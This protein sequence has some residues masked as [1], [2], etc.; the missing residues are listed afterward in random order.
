M[1][2]VH[3]EL[4]A[5]GYTR[6]VG[7]LESLRSATWMRQNLR[8]DNPPI[9]LD[10]GDWVLAEKAAPY[11]DM[12][13]MIVYGGENM[14]VR[15][16]VDCT[17]QERKSLDALLKKV[18]SG[19]EKTYESQLAT[20]EYKLVVGI[21]AAT[22]PWNGKAQSVFRP[23]IHISLFR[24]EPTVENHM[25]VTVGRVDEFLS[26][27]SIN[28]ENKYLLDGFEDYLKRHSSLAQT[29]PSVVYNNTHHA[30]D[31]ILPDNNSLTWG[32]NT[33]Y[34]MLLFSLLESYTTGFNKSIDYDFG[35]A[36]NSLW[37]QFTKELM[38]YSLASFTQGGKTVLR[39]K[40]NYRRVTEEGHP[41][42]HGASMEIAGFPVSRKAV[43]NPTTPNSNDFRRKITQILA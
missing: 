24:T 19:L 21:N 20:G 31:I 1:R 7:N 14:W 12:D 42:E 35:M 17:P 36:V 39:I 27:L 5:H 22:Q 28:D 18:V 11:S 33:K 8:A 38:A 32:R 15:T 13:C 29:I 9:I 25:R 34:M 23:H 30:L 40:F 2:I 37:L 10:T 26:K 6:D 16:L 3:T 4:E 43:P 41:K